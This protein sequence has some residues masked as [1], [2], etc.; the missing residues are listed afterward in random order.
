MIIF[1][2][3]LYVDIVVNDVIGPTNI[4]V[5][6]IVYNNV[7]VESAVKNNHYLGLLS[8]TYPS[9]EGSEP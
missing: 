5:H 4:D 2:S 3:A 1:D 9:A 7:N 8:I 6:Y